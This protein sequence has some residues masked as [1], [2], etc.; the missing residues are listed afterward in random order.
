MKFNRKS[1][2]FLNVLVLSAMTSLTATY[3]GVAS[4]YL[5]HIVNFT[6]FSFGHLATTCSTP[7]F[8]RR[9]VE[10]ILTGSSATQ[11]TLTFSTHTILPA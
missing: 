8:Y 1:Q 11:N 4:P 3:G 5:S 9:T 2:P 6:E 10:N 7:V